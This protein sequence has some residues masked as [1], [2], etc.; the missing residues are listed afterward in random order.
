M[1]IVQFSTSSIARAQRHTAQAS[2]AEV[3][4]PSK[5]VRNQVGE[6]SKPLSLYSQGIKAAWFLSGIRESNCA[7][8]HASLYPVFPALR[9]RIEA[10]LKNHQQIANKW[11]PFAV[12]H[13][14]DEIVVL[15]F[16]R[17]HTWTAK[18]PVVDWLSGFI[19]SAS[20]N[21]KLSG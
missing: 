4:A 2:M 1:S 8:F 19:E 7:F 16:E 5:H 13:I 21:G 14:L 18:T 9:L 15:A 17:R 3:F 20:E 11:G 12:T 6:P 10:F